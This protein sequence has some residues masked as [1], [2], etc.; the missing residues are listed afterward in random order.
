MVAW[1][2]RGVAEVP[3]DAVNIGPRSLDPNGTLV[4]T[5]RGLGIYCGDFEGLDLNQTEAEGCCAPAGSESA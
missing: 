5:A 2:D 3:L 4:H 1:R